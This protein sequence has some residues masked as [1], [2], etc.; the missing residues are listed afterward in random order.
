M[1]TVLPSLKLA[2]LLFLTGMGSSAFA[3]QTVKAP[4][5]FR[6]AFYSIL[7]GTEATYSVHK[8]PG[9]AYYWNYPSSWKMVKGQGTSEITFATDKNSASG[10]VTV[11]EVKGND[12]RVTQIKVTV[13][14]G[15]MVQ[16]KAEIPAVF[17]MKVTPAVSRNNFNV[18]LT[19]DN[20]KDAMQLRVVDML[21]RV[22]EQSQ[23]AANSQMQLGAA[24][25]AGVYIVEVRQGNQQKQIKVIKQ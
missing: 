23:A 24:Y 4:L 5:M 17:D 10:I 7:S 6:S 22:V 13:V 3:Q 18:Q 15:R 1:K 12:R 2:L 20:V 25:K 16:P 8:A 14:N 19:S 21:G 9:A 11:E